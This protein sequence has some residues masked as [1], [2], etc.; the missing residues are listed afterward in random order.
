MSFDFSKVWTRA[1]T[2]DLCVEQCGGKCCSMDLQVNM[3]KNEVVRLAELAGG[4]IV[5]NYDETKLKAPYSMSIKGG[6][7]FLKDGACSIHEERPQACRN[8]P[9]CPTEACAVWSV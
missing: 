1:A 7:Q 8:F 4:T 2:Y 3:A 6:C 9:S 5:V